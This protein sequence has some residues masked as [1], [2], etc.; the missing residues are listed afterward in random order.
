M[1]EPGSEWLDTVAA[2]G[3][4]PWS[5]EAWIECCAARVLVLDPRI[6]AELARKVVGTLSR[7]AHWR[8]MDP[9][10]AAAEIYRP[11]PC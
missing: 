5:D 8:R 10:T 11:V 3:P 6:G 2:V 4:L 7:R 9:E 1:S